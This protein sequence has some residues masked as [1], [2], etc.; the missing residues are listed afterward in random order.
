VKVKTP[1]SRN[2]MKLG[3][4]GFLILILPICA[5]NSKTIKAQTHRQ[6]S[7]LEDKRILVLYSYGYSLPSYHKFNPTFIS[8]MENAGVK[9]SD[10]FFEYLDLSRISDK[11]Q[12]E[13]LTGILR[14]K[15][16]KI[17]IDLVITIHAPSMLLFQNEAKDIFPNVP[18][19]SWIMQEGFKREDAEKRSVQLFAGLDVRGTLEAA[20]ELF[21]NTRRVLFISGTFQIDTQTEREAEDIFAQWGSKLQFEYTSHLSVEEVL[22]RVA[23]L[24]PQSIVIYWNVLRDKTGRTFIPT[25]VGRIV[26]KTANAPVFCLYD[27]LL[28]LGVVGG[29][30]QS[31]SAGGART[32]NLALDILNRRID[33]A[34][35]PEAITVSP[36]LMF[37]WKQLQRWGVDKSKLPEASIIIN[38]PHSFWLDHKWYLALAGIILTGQS[39]LI[40][41]LLIHRH[42]RKSAE[43]S[44][45]KAE[46]K[47]RNIFEGALE[48]IY[49]TSPEGK[50]L[51]ANPA[52]AKMLGYDSPEDVV[53]SITD[54]GYQVWADPNQRLDYI[55]L[56]EE[57]GTLL[58]YECEYY[59]KDKTKIW[60][61]LNA[62]RVPGPSGETL[63]YSGFIEDITD[64]KRVEQA[65]AESRAQIIALFDST[66]DFIWSVDPVN[67]GV[68]TWNKSFGDYFT[69]ERGIELRVGMTPEQLV[70][71]EFVSQWDEMFM[72]ALREGSFVTEYTVITGNIILLLTFNLLRQDGDIFGISIFGKDITERKRV[73]EELRKSEERYRALVDTSADW[74]WEVDA[75][76]RYTYADPKI[77]MI[78]GYAPGEVL[79]RS[80]FDFMPEEEALRV[81]ALFNEIAVDR[82]P[83]SGLINLNLHKDGREVV[84]E[85]SGTPICGSNGDLLGYRGMDRDVTERVLAE[86]ELRRSE[87]RF[88]KV[89]EDSP[90]GIG[91]SRAGLIVFVN[92]KYLEM[93]GYQNLSEVIGQPV[94]NHLVPE[95]REEIAQRIRRRSKDFD[96]PAEYIGEALRKDGSSFTAHVG[97]SL[98]RFPE[99]L[100]SIAFFLDI[101]ERIK[102]EEE[103][104]KYREHLEEMIE[105]RTAELVIAKER[106]EAADL[107][108][109]VFL[110]TMSH[111]LRTPL[112][113]IIGF[114]GVLQQELSGPLNEEQKK[115][116][117]MV[118]ASGSHL[119]DLINDVLDISKIEAG[120]LEVSIEPFDLRAVVQKVFQ[121]VRP[122]AT[123]K[124]I[125]LELEIAPDVKSISSDRRRV[126]Q[127]LLN[128]LSNAIKFTD[129][130]KVCVKCSVNAQAASIDVADTG[131]GIKREDM[132][133]LFKPF[134]QVQTG[135]GRHFEGTGL[136]LSICRKLL[137]LLGGKIAVASEWGKGSTFSFTLP[138]E[139]LRDESQNTLH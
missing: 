72:R 35:H 33:L 89:I 127:I 63:H 96:L 135:A 30:L 139:R 102:A 9:N 62:R 40:I 68:V 48:G 114:T 75:E 113:S 131:I 5:L 81:K 20:L 8:V 45:R 4:L 15:Y 109:S 24:P 59:R 57:H 6:P 117:G 44:L 78:L 132:E 76:A 50:N 69:K 84:L 51:T 66:N 70:P 112:N 56:L 71:R 18:S 34:E 74:V 82:R 14:H 47:Y 122:L 43:V 25:D 92:K 120:Q 28:G 80:P 108:K 61:S 87:E 126:E 39:L 27:T 46:E 103:L 79:G 133:L 116:L 2:S 118:R 130:G 13:A 65:L 83:F 104:R 121:S 10:L 88:R 29:S 93:F 86:I 91:A 97:N 32:A 101:T 26:A 134:Q 12:R 23:N 22:E 19:I 137:D 129:E 31:Y 17:K 52:L 77:Q 64:R 138:L 49:E 85:T 21:P 37:D 55:R 125:G 105:E 16:S 7:G 73:E 124:C 106:A 98:V 123:K 67:F 1:Y 38:Y 11:E 107:V 3:L 110:A 41:G 95:V 111:E 94:I 90:M 42:R 119:L 53:S 54:S 115:Q 99:G 58:R 36:V 100:T 128:L 136:G 60:V